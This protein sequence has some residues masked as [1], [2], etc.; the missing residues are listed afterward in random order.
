[1]SLVGGPRSVVPSRP[2][3]WNRYTRLCV[4][5]HTHPFPAQHVSSSILRTASSPPPHHHWAWVILQVSSCS[6]DTTGPPTLCPSPPAAELGQGFW[7]LS[8]LCRYAFR[9]EPLGK[10]GKE[11][12]NWVGPGDDLSRRQFCPLITRRL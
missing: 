8:G 10:E 7:R 4:S 2:C 3:R 11:T 9:K 12:G 5:L 1:M 6:Q